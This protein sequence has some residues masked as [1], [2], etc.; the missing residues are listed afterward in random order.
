VVAPIGEVR[1]LHVRH[2][3]A[4][5]RL[6]HCESN[7]GLDVGA[8]AVGDVLVKRRCTVLFSSAGRRVELIRCFRAD[9]AALGIDLSVLASDMRP[10]WSAACQEAD[11]CFEVPRCTA[12]DFVETLHGICARWEV[13]LVVPTIDPELDV[14]CRQVDA[15]RAI[16]TEVVIAAPAVVGLARDKL[17]TAEFLCANRIPAPRTVAAEAFDPHGGDWSWPVL[18]KPR[19]GSSSIGVRRLD[20]PSAWPEA[21]SLEGNA[22]Q[23]RLEGAEYTVNLFFDRGG[24]LRCVIPHLR[25]EVRGGEVSKG[26]TA[27]HD[28]LEAI[29]WS[30]GRLLPGARGPLCYQAIVDRAGRASVFEINARFG[31]GYPLAHHAGATFARWLLEEAVGLEPTCHNDWRDGVRMLRYDAAL[32]R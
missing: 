17:R 15:F 9:A 11:A 19:A 26:I 28:A 32:F 6:K 3:P 1:R 29:G 7:L 4:A 12:P 31:G 10:P 13:D 16:G 30:L 5:P 27:R 14:L 20:R 2:P 21:G 23:E 18:V 25:H 24:A 22:V 8:R